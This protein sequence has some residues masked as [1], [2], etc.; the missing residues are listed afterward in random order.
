M[1]K[2]LKMKPSASIISLA[3]AAL[4]CIDSSQAS[5]AAAVGDEV[6]AE[7]DSIVQVFNSITVQYGPDTMLAAKIRLKDGITMHAAV[8]DINEL[9]RKLKARIPNLKWLFIEPDVTD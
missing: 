2:R 4:L 8:Q 1:A 9:E 7:Q 5:E 6:I 3:I